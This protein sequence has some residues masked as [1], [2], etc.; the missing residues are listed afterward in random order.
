LPHVYVATELRL[1]LVGL[2]Q[3]GTTAPRLAY[4]RLELVC[5]VTGALSR[6]LAALL[7]LATIPGALAGVVLEKLIESKLRSPVL[8]AVTTAGSAIVMWIADRRA[9][10]PPATPGDPRERVSPGHALTVGCAQALAPLPGTSPP[11]F[12]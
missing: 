8:I 10:A 11:A 9:A 7:V 1:S 5:M 12:T 4:F 2:R 6:R 3:R